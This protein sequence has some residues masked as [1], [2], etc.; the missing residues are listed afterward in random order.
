MNW[1]FWQKK[2]EKETAEG[3]TAKLPGPKR[4]PEPVGRYLVVHLDQEPDWVWH[5]ECVV[6]SH[7]EGKSSFDIRVFD[8]SR[9]DSDNVVVKNFN[10]LDAHPNL[11]LY[12]GWYD[13]KSMQVEIVAAKEMATAR[14][15]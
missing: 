11:I 9:A 6:R 4:I 7:G 14:A 5:L 2:P 8:R 13:K 15:A 10:S 12:E 1:K 3:K